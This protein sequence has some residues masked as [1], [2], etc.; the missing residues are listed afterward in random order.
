MIAWDMNILSDKRLKPN[1]PN[2]TVVHKDAEEWIST[3]RCQRT[4]ILTTEQEKVE[5]YQDLAHEI[6]RNHRATRVTIKPIVIGSLGTISGNA[7]AWYGRLRLPN[8]FGNAQLLAIR[9]TA[10]ILR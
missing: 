3:K 5:R 1:R 2:I 10:H 7:K 9:G 4:K 8:I 6:K